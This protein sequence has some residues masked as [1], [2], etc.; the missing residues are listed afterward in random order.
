[1]DYLQATQILI[2][3][4]DILVT[5]FVAFWIVKSVQTKIDSEKVLKD[6]LSSELIQLRTDLRAFLDVLI[7]GEMEAQ[8]IKR[9]HNLLRVRINDL[10]SV[11]NRKFRVDKKYLAAYRQNLLK[12]VENDNKY[13]NAFVNNEKVHFSEVTIKRLHELRVNN[14]HLFN[15]ILIK[16]YDSKS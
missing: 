1:M 6:F 11:L 4:I 12:I 15:D 16:M 10:L 5:A 13:I 7:R 3:L 14:D 9:D 8:S 2:G